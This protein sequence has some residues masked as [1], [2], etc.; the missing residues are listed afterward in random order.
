MNDTEEV[1]C[2]LE[3]VTATL[4]LSK[5]NYSN[6]NSDK[7]GDAISKLEELRNSYTEKMQ[8]LLTKKFNI[9]EKI[10][11]IKQP[12][13]NILFYRYARG[14]NWNDVADELGYTRDYVCEL[15]GEALYLYSKS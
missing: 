7:F 15:H 13:K 2:Q 5:T 14:K 10:E 8:E 3:K 4:S 9:D 6:N 12:Y 1:K 11:K